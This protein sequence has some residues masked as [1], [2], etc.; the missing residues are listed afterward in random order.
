ML[1]GKLAMEFHK[2]SLHY[3]SLKQS[4]SLDRIF[5]HDLSLFPLAIFAAAIWPLAYW[6]EVGVVVQADVVWHEFSFDRLI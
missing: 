4:H 5:N 6:I 2:L 3:T 1:T